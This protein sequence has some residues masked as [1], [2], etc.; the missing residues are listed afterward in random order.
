MFKKINYLVIIILFFLFFI[1]NLHINAS[2]VKN[3]ENHFFLQTSFYSRH[4]SNNARH[5]NDQE[6]IGLEYHLTDS[7]LYG[8]ALF[9]NSFSQP[10]F[11]IYTGKTYSWKQY[12]QFKLTKKITFGI[13]HGYDD[14]NGKYD[15]FLNKVGTFP[16][17]V[18][19]IGIEYKGIE[20]D[21]APFASAGF[22]INM[23]VKF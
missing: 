2:E 12:H 22:I 18:P 5:N 21:I 7:S 9:N 20:L 13:I 8:L 14:E 3:K 11:Y 6:L 4:W 16:A 23:G 15:G 1:P 10:C 19:G 17:I